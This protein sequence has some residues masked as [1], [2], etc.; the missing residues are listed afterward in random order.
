MKRATLLALLVVAILVIAQPA[1]QPAAATQG[2]LT[3]SWWTVDGGGGLSALDSY[4]L[5]GTAGQ[6]DAGWMSGN[7][8]VLL[9][10]YWGG[11]PRAGSS[12]AYYLP[13]VGKSS[14]R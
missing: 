3:I 4:E 1:S 10:G 7:N 11:G 13:L 6:P 8:L 9:S 12:W 2:E 14:S 5:A